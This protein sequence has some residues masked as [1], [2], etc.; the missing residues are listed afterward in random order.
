MCSIVY[1]IRDGI[2][3]NRP[4]NDTVSTLLRGYMP[5]RSHGHILHRIY[6][7]CSH[8]RMLLVMVLVDN[9]FVNNYRSYSVNVSA[10]YK[11]TFKHLFLHTGLSSDVV[12]KL[13]MSLYKLG[14]CV[15]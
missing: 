14:D 10:T 13:P 11:N 2:R 6:R 7:R 5:S 3:P 15:C 12:N 1:H 9:S 4:Q 8:Y